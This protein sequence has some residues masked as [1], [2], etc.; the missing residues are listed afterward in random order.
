M[1]QI[2]WKKNEDGYMVTKKWENKRCFN[3]KMLMLMHSSLVEPCLC[4]I[5]TKTKCIGELF[6]LSKTRLLIF[7]FTRNNDRMLPTKCK[8]LKKFTF[9]VHLF[10]NLHILFHQFFNVL[11]FFQLNQSCGEYLVRSSQ[12]CCTYAF[13]CILLLFWW[14]WIKLYFLMQRQAIIFLS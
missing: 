4:S 10:V 12:Y 9:C 6:S 14:A 13:I 3:R 11:N 8:V 5:C 2:S 7:S 1:H